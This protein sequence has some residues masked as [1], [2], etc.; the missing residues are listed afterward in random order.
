[1]DLALRLVVF[2]GEALELGRLEDWYSRH[3]DDAPVLVNMYGITETTVHVTYQA[4]DRAYAATA[5][6]SVIGTG[7]PD[8]R[9]YVLDER[10][11]PVPPGVVGE[12]YVAGAGLARGYWNRPALTA[13]RFVPDP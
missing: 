8:L 10:L 11:R 3:P 4:L 9:L 2:G 7:I 12:L 6:G 5:T 1:A 13:E